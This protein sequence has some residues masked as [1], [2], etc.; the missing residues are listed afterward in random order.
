M[1]K[2]LNIVQVK[3]S[4]IIP[5]DLNAKKHDQ[6]QINNVAE[7]IKQF[8]FRQPI[9]LD[10]DNVIIIGHCRWL[11]SKKLKLDT[12]PCHYAEELTE[13]QVIKLRNLDN[14][15]NESE[16]DF[17][18]LKDQVADISF[19][20]FDIDWGIP[21]IEENEPI[22]TF[23]DIPPEVDE[24]NEPITKLGDIWQLGEHRL[25]CGDSTDSET[26]ARLMDGAK[27]DMVLTDPPYNANYEGKTKDKLTIQNDK[28]ERSAFEDFLTNAFYNLS[29][30]LKEGG[31]YYVWHASRFQK[32]FENALNRNGIQV[33]QQLIWVKNTLIL[34]RS[35]YQWKHEPCLYGWKDGAHYFI[36]D[37]TQTTVY[38][39]SNID[40][41]KLKKEEMLKLLQDIF[42]EKQSTTV[43]KEDKPARSSEHPTMKPIKLLAVQIKNSSKLKEGVLD[44][45]GGSGSTL[46]AC[47]QLN[48]KCY[49]MELDPKYCDVI[50]KRWENL[51]N[52]KAIRL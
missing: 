30:Y 24:E 9:V 38:E 43:I 51:T 10:K 39:D 48:R 18:L 8:G 4:E 17:D 6:V 28:M 47:E 50:I 49:M 3:V 34:G 31:A 22:S 11:A 32:E 45:F 36:D 44:L 1:N 23:E 16:W 7:S 12:V 46:I 2:E 35:D 19:D 37:R 42:A 52:K 41:K 13:E 26:V 29:E 40:L 33:R 27:A 20:G 21:D 25:M 15:L 5:Y 14:K